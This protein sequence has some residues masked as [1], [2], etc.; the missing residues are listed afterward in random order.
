MYL[1]SPDR[2]SYLVSIDL[3]AVNAIIKAT[4]M[5]TENLLFQDLSFH[6]KGHEG[7]I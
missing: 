1:E 6:R 4:D 5:K 3:E 7:E 2:V